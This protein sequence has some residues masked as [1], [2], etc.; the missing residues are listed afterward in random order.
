MC[1]HFVQL[2]TMRVASNDWLQNAQIC[3]IVKENVKD[4]ELEVKRHALETNT[5][6][7]TVA[8]SRNASVN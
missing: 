4:I 2:L 3:C 7:F 5:C 6:Q 8:N 1:F